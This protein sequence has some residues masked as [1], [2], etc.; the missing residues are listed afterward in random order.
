[1]LLHSAP[2]AAVL[3]AVVPS[4]S[5]PLPSPPPQETAPPGATAEDD[6]T[7]GDIRPLSLQDA[8]ALALSNN[9]GLERAQIESEAA[10]FDALSTWGAFD[11]VFDLAGS[12]TNSESEGGSALFGGEVVSNEDTRFDLDLARPLTTG[13]SFQF[14][15]DTALSVTDNQFANAPELY[16]S[17]LSLTYVQPLMRGAWKEYNTA[18]QREAEVTEQR[19]MEER[20]EA[21]QFLIHDVEVAY[22]ELVAAQ[23][24]LQV[25][26]AALE[27][28]EEQ[29]TR[30]EARLRAGDGTEVDVLQA[31]TEVATRTETLLQR[32]NDVAQRSDDLKMLIVR[33]KTS[34]LWTRQIQTTSS[35]PEADPAELI[36]PDWIDAY[37]I[38]VGR[39][40]ELRTARLDVDIAR[41]R[42]TRAQS[43]RL[44]GLD[45]QLSASSGAFDEDVEE[46]LR[47]TARFQFPRYAATISYNMPL[48][49]RTAS[50]NERAARERLRGSQVALEELEVTALADVRRAIREVRFRAAA[51]IAAEQSFALA[52]RQL[53]AEQQRFEADLTTTFEVLQFQQTAIESASSRT[54]ARAE[55]AKSLVGLQRAQGLIGEAVDPN[56]N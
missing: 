43:E 23:E 22:W 3:A 21:R 20:R 42:L 27:L 25:A 13:G 14:H 45:L 49:N 46:A 16:Q 53:E 17:G 9:L 51:V 41:I 24:Q 44:Y 10:R 55:Y 31:Q 28:G 38:A 7:G 5:S 36:V 54:M 37:Q 34:E 2:L 39:R 6:L 8:L 18:N 47:D 19:R 35:L 33:D 1:M 52:R 30:E 56:R 40:S 50:N 48:Q 26:Q 15:F 12:Y 4:G 32:E 11:W 29:I